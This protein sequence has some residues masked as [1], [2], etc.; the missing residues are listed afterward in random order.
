MCQEPVSL[1]ASSSLRGEGA[2][3]WTHHRAAVLCEVEVGLLDEQDRANGQ[4][5]RESRSA[6]DEREGRAVQVNLA[7]AA[8]GVLAAVPEGDA[9][10]SA[11]TTITMATDEARASET[12][13][14]KTVATSLQG[15]DAERTSKYRPWSSKGRR[16]LG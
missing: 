8:A 11:M 3:S 13:P 9:R 5:R 7:R 16:A 14:M 2:P 1:S 10:G 6:F 12:H 4:G 15:F